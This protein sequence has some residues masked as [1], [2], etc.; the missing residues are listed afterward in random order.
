MEES[1]AMVH[2]VP[3]LIEACLYGCYDVVWVVSCGHEEQRRR[4]ALRLG[5]EEAAEAFLQTQLPTRAKLAFADLVIR[6]DRP[7]RAMREAVAEGLARTL[8]N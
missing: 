4:L 2:E 1:S 6:S 5:S 3:L 7:L 8:R